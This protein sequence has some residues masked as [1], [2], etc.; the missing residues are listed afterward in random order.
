MGHL[1]WRGADHLSEM[2]TNPQLD[3]GARG[4]RLPSRVLGVAGVSTAVREGEGTA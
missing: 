3:R 4:L 1:C 2:S